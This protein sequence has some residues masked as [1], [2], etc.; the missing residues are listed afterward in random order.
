MHGTADPAKDESVF[1]T[2]RDRS[3][4]E[5]Y[6]VQGDFNDGDEYLSEICVNGHMMCE[7]CHA[8]WERTNNRCPFCRVD[9]IPSRNAR[10]M[11]VFHT[12]EIAEQQARNCM[13]G[14]TLG[15]LSRIPRTLLQGGFNIRIFAHN[16][17]Y[18]D[19]GSFM[20]PGGG[21]R[22]QP[23]E[24]TTR[25]LFEIQ[26]PDMTVASMMRRMQIYSNELNHP[27][28]HE[29]IDAALWNLCIVKKDEYINGCFMNTYKQIDNNLRIVD[30]P[31]FVF[32]YETQ[33]LA[34][35]M[36]LHEE[37]WTGMIVPGIATLNEIAS[38]AHINN[39]RTKELMVEMNS[40]E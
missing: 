3:W 35:F 15:N 11:Q 21:I 33:N 2:L 28:K 17:S 14:D 31:E 8:T 26:E 20:P 29:R 13:L 30:I 39:Q 32:D 10:K 37:H 25:Y 5:G 7:K 23:I 34:I 36:D 6:D 40:D 9:L 1:D 24:S 38:V 22:P 4:Q 19:F 12:D 18:C 27:V 16:Y